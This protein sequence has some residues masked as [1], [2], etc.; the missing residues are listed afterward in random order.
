[1]DFINLPNNFKIVYTKYNNETIDDKVI[2]AKLYLNNELVGNFIDIIDDVKLQY[3][4]KNVFTSNTVKTINENIELIFDG[5]RE[6][7]Y[8]IV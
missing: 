1:M 8:N 3:I 5:Y 2:T 4:D 7:L 6:L